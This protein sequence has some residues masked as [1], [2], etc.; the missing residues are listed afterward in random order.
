MKGPL[1]LL[2][3]AGCSNAPP[4]IPLVALSPTFAQTGDDLTV[5]VQEPAKDV[6]HADLA[7]RVRWLRDGEVVEGLNTDTLPA[8]FTAKG[9]DW[10]VEVSAS[11]GDQWGEPGTDTVR[12]RN[13][14]PTGIVRI[15]PLD[16]TT[17][18]DLTCQ[19]ITQDADGDEVSVT[20]IWEVNGEEAGTSAQL[21]AENFSEGD[22]VTCSPILDDG[23]ELVDLPTSEAVYPTNGPPI[24]QAQFIPANSLRTNTN[25]TISVSVDDP[26]G[27]GT[28]TEILWMVDGIPV[29]HGGITLDG[30]T[31]F[32]KGQ[33]V[34]V[35]VVATDSGGRSARTILSEVVE[36]TA[37]EAP[38]VEVGPEALTVDTDIHCVPSG[39]EDPDGDEVSYRLRWEVDGIET[40]A[41]EDGDLA[42]DTIPAANTSTGAVW[43]CFAEA[44]DGEDTSEE[45][46]G[47]SNAVGEGTA[48]LS[49][50]WFYG[51]KKN[52]GA[53][54]AIESAG[55]TNG[56]GVP[57]ILIGAPY[58]DTANTDSGAAYLILG[59]TTG[60][61]SLKYADM[62]LSG[63]GQGDDLTGFSL[64]GGGDIDADGYD[65]FLVS[66]IGF[67][68]MSDNKGLVYVVYGPI[69][70]QQNHD[71]L[72]D[73]LEG[74]NAGDGAG[75]GLALIG[76]QNGDGT[77]E[78]MIG[79]SGSDEAGTGAGIS[80]LIYGPISGPV[81]LDLVD[82]RFEGENLG[83]YAGD[84]IANP[85]DVNGDGVGDIL[86]GANGEDTGGT[87]NAG[88]AYIIY[89]PVSSGR[90]LSLADAKLIGERPEDYAGSTVMH[91]GDLNDDGFDDLFIGANRES[92]NGEDAGAVY[93]Q[94][95]PV[96]GTLDLSLADG[97]LLGD[98][99]GDKAGISHA[100]VGDLTGDGITELIVG[101][102]YH[103]G[104]TVVDAGA[105]Y[106]VDGS[107]VGG[108]TE[109]ADAWFIIHGTSR[110]GEF[111]RSLTGPGD[112]DLDGVPD[113]LVGASGA[114][115]DST[116]VGAVFFF[117]GADLQP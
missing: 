48:A 55:D 30:E 72:P 8:K 81:P 70:D 117:S 28:T 90:N 12:I 52:D 42:D 71:S 99:A 75:I 22:K 31:W 34:S 89:G 44:F 78:L 110:D 79:A 92:T 19:V 100:A 77:A 93:I 27:D 108:V 2:L 104:G 67:Q 43:A 21:A 3:A 114:A 39:G 57:D 102:P 10:T 53:G 25:L 63:A 9:E 112:M 23:N 37:P 111:G 41:A 40:N 116:T 88:A 14:R 58:A 95:G 18:D 74:E 11:D 109:L 98:E 49:S 26:D 86:F 76:D 24:I 47:L 5:I 15:L 101:A 96:T 66:A 62:K 50:T 64:A 115:V 82:I 105:A 97:K 45:G 106:L 54:H 61:Y 68:D 59:P 4:S 65:D 20:Y 69:S 38:D 107:T 13:T 56:D 87:P 33:T 80:Y 7:Y 94:F 17:A 103:S 84:A 1:L 85:G 91:L 73:Y 46:S 32:D 60:Q 113:F 36:N 29:L 6:E 83:D 51:E 16:A 35:S